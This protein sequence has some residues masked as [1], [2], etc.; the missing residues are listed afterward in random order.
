[1]IRRYA[2]PKRIAVKEECMSE[3][4]EDQEYLSMDEASAAIGWNKAT[5]Y[6]WI[7]RLDIQ[8]HKFVGNRKAYLKAGDVERLKE[9]K[10]KPWTAGE[11][12]KK[13]AAEEGAL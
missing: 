7:K 5:V 9:V 12:E 4:V 3:T 1:M 13:S 8:T 2:G 11:K 10:A 6:E